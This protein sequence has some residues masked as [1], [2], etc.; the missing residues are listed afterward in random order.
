MKALP[1]FGNHQMELR[2]WKH[3]LR[4]LSNQVRK[5]FSMFRTFVFANY[6]FLDRKVYHLRNSQFSGIENKKFLHKIL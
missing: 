1:N 3:L 5:G 2:E 4:I 6:R